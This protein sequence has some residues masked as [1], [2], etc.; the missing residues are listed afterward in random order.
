MLAIHNLD[1]AHGFRIA[2]L[3][4][5]DPAFTA[6][7]PADPTLAPGATVM[8]PVQFTPTAAGAHTAQL[9]VVLYGNDAP[10]A[11]VNLTG[12]G[13]GHGGG[14]CNATGAPGAGLALALLALVRRR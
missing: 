11:T 2:Q 13:V 10:I 3:A 14:G 1:T 7:Q 5:D 12:Q 4:I 6:A 8:V 9:S